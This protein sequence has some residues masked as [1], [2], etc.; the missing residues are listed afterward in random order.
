MQVREG[1]RQILPESVLV[2]V[3]RID[4]EQ[5]DMV[6]VHGRGRVPIGPKHAEGSLLQGLRRG[7]DHLVFCP[8]R[9]LYRY[10]SR[11]ENLAFIPGGGVAEE[12]I[13]TGRRRLSG[14]ARPEGDA[15]LCARFQTDAEP[16]AVLEAAFDDGMAGVFQPHIMGVPVE[17]AAF[18]QDLYLTEGFPALEG[19]VILEGAVADLLGV[20]TAVRREVDVLQED[21]VHRR[22]DGNPRRLIVHNE[23]IPLRL[24]RK[25]QGRQKGG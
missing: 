9:A 6:D 21:T 18:V 24:R 5:G 14:R 15:V 12:D 11:R 2:P 1:L 23:V 22:L 3:E 4:G 8:F 25:G 17:G 16:A 19:V 7:Q 10:F 20:Q 13:D